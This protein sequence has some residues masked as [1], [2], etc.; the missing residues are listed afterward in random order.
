M[1]PLALGKG[2]VAQAAFRRESE[3]DEM[4]TTTCGSNF[5]KTVSNLCVV[6]FGALPVS[7]TGSK[8]ASTLSVAAD[9]SG[10]EDEPVR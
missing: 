8:R 6:A 3:F 4:G 9:V 2:G 10:D 7:T 1:P 5:A